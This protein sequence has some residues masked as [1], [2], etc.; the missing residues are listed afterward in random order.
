MS[1][2]NIY[3]SDSNY[4][5]LLTVVKSFVCEDSA[6]PW[7]HSQARRHQ[8]TQHTHSNS[9]SALLH[10]TLILTLGYTAQVHSE[11]EHL[12]TPVN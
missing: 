10:S 7:A 4:H 11:Y 9:S 6:E 8:E 12:C 1:S 5:Q 3:Q 2:I